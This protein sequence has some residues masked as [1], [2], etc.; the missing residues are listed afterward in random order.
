MPKPTRRNGLFPRLV[1]DEHG[2]TLIE[3][4]VAVLILGLL[5]AIAIPTFLSRRTNGGDAVAK[6]LVNTAQQ[7]AMMYGL[8]NSFL[9]MTPSALS[10]VEPTINITPNGKAVL[11]NAS[12]TSGGFILTVVSS[13]ADTFNVTYSNGRA[14][15]TCIVAVG[16]GNTTTNSGGGCRNGTW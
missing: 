9:T 13:T 7:E 8:T 16:N 1:S 12:P 11:V 3:L 10:G 2:F 15:R 14:T 6:G 5:A 4:L